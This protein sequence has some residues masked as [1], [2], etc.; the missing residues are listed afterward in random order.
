M[1]LQQTRDLAVVDLYNGMRSELMQMRV[2]L[3]F[4]EKRAG[5]VD[6]NIY[7]ETC[8]ADGLISIAFVQQLNSV[9]LQPVILPREAGFI[10]SHLN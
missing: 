8:T 1:Q 7:I 4:A 5:E 10:P 6:H 9:T 3:S 2:A